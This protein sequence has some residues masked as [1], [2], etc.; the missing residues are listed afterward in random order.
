M[1]LWLQH[2][3]QVKLCLVFYTL[4]GERSLA[5]EQLCACCTEPAGGGK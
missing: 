5:S 4:E 2:S 3:A 1:Y